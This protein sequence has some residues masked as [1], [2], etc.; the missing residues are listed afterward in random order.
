MPKKP[1][2]ICI[3]SLKAF[4]L[5]ISGALGFVLIITIFPVM[6]SLLLIDFPLWRVIKENSALLVPLSI[7][8][9]FISPG[10]GFAATILRYKRTLW[11]MIIGIVSYWLAVLFV[12]LVFSNFTLLNE[13]LFNVFI[14][15]L[16][17]IFAYSFFSLPV[18]IPVILLF[19]K[20]S[21][22]DY[23]DTSII[24]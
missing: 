10:L 17:S 14:L 7:F 8:S 21:R 16:W 24:S 3:N 19:E 22:P 1:E 20:W 4:L 12:M 11:L 15:A 23:S 9:F 6:G 13:N 5:L 2:L 18:L